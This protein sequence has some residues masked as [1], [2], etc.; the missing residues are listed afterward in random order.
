LAGSLWNL[1]ASKA[2]SIFGK[3]CK[4]SG[5][6]CRFWIPALE[7]DNGNQDHP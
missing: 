7:V 2:L 1:V 4:L 5:R 3:L 6:D